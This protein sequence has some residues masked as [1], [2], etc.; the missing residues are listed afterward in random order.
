[1]FGADKIQLGTQVVSVT[2]N[3]LYVD[4]NHANLSTSGVAPNLNLL[5]IPIS[6]NVYGAVSALMGLPSGFIQSNLS[7]TTIKIPYWI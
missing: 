3:T 1:M 6:I 2:G 4:G 5:T 7:G